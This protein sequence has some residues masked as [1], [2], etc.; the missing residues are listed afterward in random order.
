MAMAVGA[1]LSQIADPPLLYT[2]EL[3]GT[4]T[5]DAIAAPGVG[6]KI[7]LGHV[8]LT[9]VSGSA[10]PVSI[11]FGTTDKI[12]LNTTTAAPVVATFP[13]GGR[14]MTAD[15]E[16][17]QVKVDTASA[18]VRVSILYWVIKS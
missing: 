12:L 15:N 9:Q 14:P 1:F 16:K 17:V 11:R 3:T 5:T 6:S 18:V 7:V 10:C 2:A 8:I 13:F 4:S